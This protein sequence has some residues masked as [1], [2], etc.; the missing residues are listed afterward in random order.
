MA[1][2]KDLALLGSDVNLLDRLA[3]SVGHLKESRGILLP[4]IGVAGGG[5]NGTA[6]GE[7]RRTAKIGRHLGQV[8]KRALGGFARNRLTRLRV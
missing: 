3:A 4:T 2:G 5:K 6:G 7:D 8:G 1:Q